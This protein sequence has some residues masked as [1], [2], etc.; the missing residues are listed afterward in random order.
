[1]KN[2]LLVFLVLL[3]SCSTSPGSER[4]ADSTVNASEPTLQ[5]SANDSTLYVNM[6][7]Y[8]MDTD[9]FYVSLVPN[10][11][12]TEEYFNFLSDKADSVV[13]Q[14]E[15]SGRF[16]L[17]MAIAKEA[18]DLRDLGEIKIY[19]AQHQFLTNAKLKRAEYVVDMNGH[20]VA[21]FKPEKV[22]PRDGDSFY[23]L[24]MAKV[25]LK[26]IKTQ[27]IESDE[28]TERIKKN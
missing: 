26:S 28:L 21:V 4:M 24:G 16:R 19:N 3:F 7:G 5:S 15:G 2:L 1:M 9:E 20:F 6:V 18:F 23:C 10:K 25:G 17:P 12:M 13:F 27:T 22:V 14:D 11:P 8:F